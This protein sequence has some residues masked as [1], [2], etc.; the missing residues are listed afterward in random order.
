MLLELAKPVTLLASILSLLGVFHAAFLAPETTL[1][2]RLYDSL[3]LLALAA[4]VSLISG[5]V[6]QKQQQAV[7][8][9]VRVRAMRLT[10]TFPVQVFFWATGIMS[11][12]FLL[13]WYVE[14][15]ILPYRNMPF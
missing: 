3:A 8:H 13:A 10:E 15:Y 12:L 2:Q 14:T 4:A 5:I 11:A 9:L 1:E 7:I 6:F